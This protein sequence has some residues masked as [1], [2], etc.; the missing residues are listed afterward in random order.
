MKKIINGCSYLCGGSA[1]L[2][3]L[4]IFCMAEKIKYKKFA[5]LVEKTM[6]L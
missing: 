1:G 6:Q 3:Y 5:Y 4:K 2:V